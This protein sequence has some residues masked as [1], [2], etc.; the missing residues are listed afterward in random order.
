MKVFVPMS[1]AILGHNAEL[2]QRLVPFD[3]SYLT[4]SQERR[5][6][7]KPSNW[8]NDSNYEQARE[9]LFANSGVIVLN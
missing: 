3:P 5:R 7:H 8:V 2:C 1:D 6:G 9:R 4:E